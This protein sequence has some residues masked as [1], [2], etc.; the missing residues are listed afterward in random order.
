MLVS[1]FF[2][3]SMFLFMCLSVSWVFIS[4]RWKFLVS[5]AR[6]GIKMQNI[7]IKNMF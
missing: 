3:F 4:L 5:L 6:L 7:R 2:F 1:F